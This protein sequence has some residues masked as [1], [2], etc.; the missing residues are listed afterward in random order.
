MHYFYKQFSLALKMAQRA[1]SLDNSRSVIWLQ[2][3]HAQAALGLANMA[4]TSFE[5]V[6]HLDP[7]CPEAVRGLERLS[8]RGRLAQ[9]ADRLRGLFH[10]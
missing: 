2:L 5:Q 7:R 8:H 10:R 4:I 3:G 6:L 9:I 1:L